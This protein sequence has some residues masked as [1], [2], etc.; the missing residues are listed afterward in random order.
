MKGSYKEEKKFKVGKS[1]E[2]SKKL[3]AGAFGEIF[4]GVNTKTNMQVAIKFEPV[5]TKHPQLYYECKLY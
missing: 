4:K 2:C 1:F 5:N 3:G